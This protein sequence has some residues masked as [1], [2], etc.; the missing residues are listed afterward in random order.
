MV[1]RGKAADNRT[2]TSTPWSYSSV[3]SGQY[4]G[5]TSYR[6]E[7]LGLFS[8]PN[9]LVC[10]DGSVCRVACFELLFS[11]NSAHS[12]DWF[13]MAVST[14]LAPAGAVWG[15]TFHSRVLGSFVEG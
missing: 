10:A 15:T 13:S 14:H 3:G 8:S 7:L 9:F 1:P 6:R 2:V 12:A 4:T 5:E 11:A